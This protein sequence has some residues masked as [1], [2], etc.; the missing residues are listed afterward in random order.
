MLATFTHLNELSVIACTLQNT[1][2]FLKLILHMK[3]PE[4]QV[5]I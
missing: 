2:M 3:T 1:E 4:L 5:I